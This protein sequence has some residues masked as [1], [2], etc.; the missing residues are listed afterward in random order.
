MSNDN[1]EVVRKRLGAVTAYRYA[2][3]QG[4]TGTEQ[5]FAALMASYAT[6]AEEAS[7]SAASAAASATAAAESASAAA[8]SATSLV[9]DTEP[10]EGSI[11]PVASGAVYD[12]REDL[13]EDLINSTNNALDAIK[14]AKT[15]TG[16]SFLTDSMAGNI[17]IST[18]ENVEI[19]C[20][21]KNIYPYKTVPIYTY[22]WSRVTS[23]ETMPNP[24]FLKGGHTYIISVDPDMSLSKFRFNMK[25]CKNDAD[26][27]WITDNAIV[28]FHNY[29]KT[30]LT[31]YSTG[32]NSFISSTNYN[33]RGR[34]FVTPTEDIYADFTTD[35]AV[36]TNPMIE[37]SDA[38]VQSEHEKYRL[39]ADEIVSGTYKLK[40]V[41]GICT[42]YAVSGTFDATYSKVAI[43]P[44]S[45]AVIND[46][47]AYIYNGD[48]TSLLKETRAVNLTG[49][50]GS[51]VDLTPLDGAA[52]G[53]Y[54]LLIKDI[55]PG[56]K[57]QIYT[58]AGTVSRPW[59]FLDE[60]NALLS[61]SP[62][63]YAEGV[64]IKAPANSRKLLVQVGKAH[65]SK[66]NV[67]RNSSF[68]F[69]T[70]GTKIG[71]LDQND[72]TL[73]VENIE[74]A[75]SLRKGDSTTSVKDR[76]D[77][78]TLVHFSDIH[79]AV[80]NIERVLNFADE[81]DDY[82]MGVIHTGDAPATYYGNDNPFAYVGGNRIMEVVGNHECWIEGDTWPSPY[83][84][85]AAQVY[86][87]YIAPY[88]ASWDV[89]PA[90]ENLCY[91][92]KDYETANLRLIVLDCMHYDSIQET[93]FT[94]T[95]AGA[96]TL[97]YRVVAVTHYPAQ[98]GINNFD[99]TFCTYGET[100]NPISDPAEG[101]Q[102]ERMSDSAFT[103][104]DTFISDGGEFVCWLSGHTHADFIGTVNNHVNQIQVIISTAK[105]I[106]TDGDSARTEGTK[107]QDCFNVFVVDGV[108]HL[109]KII[110]I[111]ASVDRYM[112]S[113]KTLCVNYLTKAIVSNH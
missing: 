81:Y 97:G 109:I 62:T 29:D 84:A 107:T 46:K 4:Y 11:R 50:I 33:N 106:N 72:K 37:V 24:V 55:I 70:T 105:T 103:V 85:T 100:R 51:T 92:Y 111:G 41:V 3:T 14:E 13:S 74:N 5:E 61:V 99:C 80:E 30:T 82:I 113:R 78:L 66:A 20:F 75:T 93:W 53:T 104:V 19:K 69:L 98:T 31:N 112:R 94:E 67:I 95:L 83:N 35:T 86:A 56:E 60:N 102:I 48:Y 32:I 1:I 16:V 8:E 59:A 65:I 58:V 89:V 25:A 15:V 34:A 38:N 39:I 108:N 36:G 23:Y 101:T 52:G 17:V 22:A 63:A 42:V 71:V 10:T 47:L 49:N 26:H 44:E 77:L 96:R 27:T 57:F 73:F 76:E 64:C 87:K 43:S 45:I 28:N 88:I 54:T 91:Y 12:L 40:S 2:V 7:G 18:E 79:G 21:G 9:V 90:G 6:V 110:R 68:S